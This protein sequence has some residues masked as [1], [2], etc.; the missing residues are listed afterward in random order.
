MIKIS[1]SHSLSWI[2]ELSVAKLNGVFFVFCLV[3]VS[4]VDILDVYS[5]RC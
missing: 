3:Q 1:V 5:V 2:H 4:I